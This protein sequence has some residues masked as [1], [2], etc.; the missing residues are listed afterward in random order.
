MTTLAIVLMGITFAVWSWRTFPH[1][2][3]LENGERRS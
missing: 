3:V 1:S 2:S